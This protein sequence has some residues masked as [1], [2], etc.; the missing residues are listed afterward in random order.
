M[1]KKVC[2]LG[3]TGS[4]GTQAL[5][6]IRQN[7]EKFEAYILTA[8][9]SADKLIEQALEFRPK[10]LVIGNQNLF[11]QVKN[12]LAGTAISVS[13]GKTSIEEITKLA[14]I[15]I[16]LAAMVGY[17]GLKPTLNALENRKTVA[18]A[19]KESLVI[20]GDLVTTLAI[21][22]GVKILPVD[23]EHSA[24]YQCLAGE[25]TASI[26]K[27]YLTASGGP[28]FGKNESELKNVTRIDALKHPNWKMGPKVTIDSATLMNKGLEVI[29]ARWLF[30]V[31]HK[32][33]EVIVHPQSIIHSMVQFVDGSIKAQMGLPDMH[34]PIQFALAW[35][36]R[37]ESF[38]KRL[39]FSEHAELT[40]FSPNSDLF[41]NLTLAYQ[42]IEAGGNM[43]CV[44]NAANEVAVEA[45][46]N[47]RIGFLDIP[48]LIEQCMEKVGFI[49]TPTLDDLI[50][51]H[52]NTQRFAKELL[53]VL[54]NKK[55]I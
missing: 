38:S 20:A 6:V 54:T 26:E 5:D 10:Y 15:D 34:L 52:E 41:R 1:P 51:T 42:A 13:S 37:I 7:P 27:I 48:V 30:G 49:S 36:E 22:K 24:I 39:N 55:G 50:G 4:I 12:A 31:S 40:F 9:N 53:I 17:A 25:S 33:I 46:L 19:N 23:S 45:F 18:L 8:N 44:L 29:E 35:P 47:D 16:V 43:P 2:I 21:N 32:K 11:L 28:F 14:D 3:S